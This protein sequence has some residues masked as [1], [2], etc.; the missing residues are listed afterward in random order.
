VGCFRLRWLRAVLAAAALLA[1]AGPAFADDPQ[2]LAPATIIASA[3]PPAHRFLDNTNALLTGVEAAA[4]IGDAVSTR[5][6]L[7][8]YPGFTREANPIA[9]P[10]VEHGWPGQIAGGLL[11]VG[12]E[13][14]GRH[15]LHE[16]G[17]HRLERLLPIALAAMEGA[18]VIHNVRGIR[19]LD[20]MLDTSR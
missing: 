3:A 16:A 1:A 11:F 13:L 8:R 10:F 15:T 12:A 7:D 9:R 14:W 2:A 20:R 19:S 18:V 6:G 5:W 17:H 4:L